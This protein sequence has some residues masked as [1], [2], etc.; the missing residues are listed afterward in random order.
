MTGMKALIGELIG[1]K[2]A[3]KTSI[4]QSIALI[5]KRKAQVDVGGF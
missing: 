1:N 5:L 2:T 4:T 3:N